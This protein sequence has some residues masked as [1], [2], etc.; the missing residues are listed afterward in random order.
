M[1]LPFKNTL[2]VVGSSRP[3]IIER[4]VDFPQPLGPSNVTK[5]PFEN[6]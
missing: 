1:S 5:S 6:L 4:S 3:A 2:P